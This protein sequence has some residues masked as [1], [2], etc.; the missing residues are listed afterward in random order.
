MTSFNQEDAVNLQLVYKKQ[1]IL[2]DTLHPHIPKVLPPPAINV[3]SNQ[4]IFKWLS[5][6]CKVKWDTDKG[7]TNTL[8]SHKTSDMEE[9]HHSRSCITKDT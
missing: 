5:T 7:K 3:L 9:F 1:S 2:S 4:Y 6:K 8:V